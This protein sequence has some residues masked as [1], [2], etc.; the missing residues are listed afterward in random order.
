MEHAINYIKKLSPKQQ[1]KTT[2]TT[3]INNNNNVTKRT[4]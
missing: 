4:V 2:T 3:T 1:T